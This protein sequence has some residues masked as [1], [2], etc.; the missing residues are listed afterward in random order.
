[1]IC[2]KKNSFIN[3]VAIIF[4]ES[5]WILKR[6]MKFGYSQPLFLEGIGYGV[7][8]TGLGGGGYGYRVNREIWD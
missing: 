4:M 5:L 1:M 3:N 7:R 2:N 8:E 6:A